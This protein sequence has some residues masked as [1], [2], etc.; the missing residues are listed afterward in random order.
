MVKLKLHASSCRLAAVLDVAASLRAVRDDADAVGLGQGRDLF[1]AA[2][3]A[4]HPE[5]RASA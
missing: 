2:D 4:A 5:A 1:R 3:P